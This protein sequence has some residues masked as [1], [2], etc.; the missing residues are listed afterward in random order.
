MSVEEREISLIA[1]EAQIACI[2]ALEGLSVQ[3]RLSLLSSLLEQDGVAHSNSEALSRARARMRQFRL[4]I[5]RSDE[6]PGVSAHAA[7]GL[8]SDDAED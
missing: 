2:V 7:A 3:E 1:D 5:E 6:A 8:P 4:H